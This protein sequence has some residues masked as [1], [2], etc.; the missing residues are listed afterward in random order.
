MAKSRVY[1][2]FLPAKQLNLS[3]DEKKAFVNVLRKM[4][5]GTIID[6]DEVPPPLG[7]GCRFDMS[8][9]MEHEC[10]SVGCIAGWAAI[11]MNLS[12]SQVFFETLARRSD[13]LLK[14]T[15][16]RADDSEASGN[17]WMYGAKTKHGARALRNFL[18][19]GKANWR[20][21]MGKDA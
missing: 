21:A 18:T 8:L 20:K 19:T 11:E 7:E 15:M 9:V 6:T 14:L 1:T 4:E 12:A 5:N 2:G 10:G 3:V 13:E 16:A 17:K